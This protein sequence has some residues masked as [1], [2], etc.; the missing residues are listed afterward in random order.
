MRSL[1]KNSSGMKAAKVKSRPEN[2]H[3]VK[4]AATRADLLVA[5]EAVFV[6]EGYER[7]Q[8]EEIAHQAG[9][10]RGAVYAHFKDK[11]DIFLAL[12]ENKA[13]GRLDSYLRDAP[14]VSFEE[15]VNTG[16]LLFLNTIEE[17][18]WPILMLEFKLFA[19]R[20]RG[21]L[22]RIQGIHKV[23]YDDVRREV[24]TD[25]FGF[26]ETE[27]DRALIGLAVLKSLPGAV[28]LERQFNPL[29][30][31]HQLLQDVLEAVFLTLVEINHRGSSRT[32]EGLHSTRVT[33]S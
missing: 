6:R 1:C 14:S 16:R 31:S 8:I 4:T 32:S 11:E 3:Q 10:T 19:L 21:S 33:E 29:M 5:A 30:R 24:L 26:T 2:K 18:N 25:E 17:E 28:A 9:R 7:A 20:S 13:E 15:R 23:L 27:K 12:L 22:E